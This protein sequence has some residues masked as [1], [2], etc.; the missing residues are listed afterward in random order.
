MEFLVEGVP[1]SW[2]SLPS[3]VITIP[4]GGEKIVDLYLRVP[5]AP[6]IRAGNFPLKIKLANQKDPAVREEVVIR[7]TIAAFESQGPVGVLMGTVQFA[8]APGGSITVPL[9]VLNRGLVQASF[10]LGVDGIPVGWVSTA[11][12]VASLKPG[13]SRE[14]SLVIRP[15]L[16][17]SS[18]AGRRKFFIVVLN[19]TVPDQVVKV[20]CLLTVAAFSQFSAVLEPQEEETGKPVSVTVKNEGNTPQTFHL[21]CESQKDQLQFE[22]LEPIVPGQAAEPV[23]PAQPQASAGPRLA[24]YSVIQIP[25]EKREHFTSSPGSAAVLF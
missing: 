5:A 22:Y 4:A 12:P 19:Q 14:I 21:V 18:Q 24:D 6:E 25:P 1:V 15:P 2:I 7:L 16:S 17:S 23:S 3:P 11:T 8:V 13:E 9:T 20:E 10:R